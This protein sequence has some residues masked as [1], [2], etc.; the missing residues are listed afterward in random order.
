M[1]TIDSIKK[2]KN[3]RYH[4]K[5]E[6]IG[7]VPTMGSLH[8]GHVSLIQ[9]SKKKNR[10]TVVSIFLNPTQFNNKD[11]LN[12]YPKDFKRDKEILKDLRVDYLFS[13]NKS[14]IYC[15]NYK[16][17][18]SEKEISKILCGR[19]RRGHFEGVLTVV[20]KLLNLVNPKNSYF[21]EKDFQQF[22]LIKGMVKAL[23]LD[24]NC[25]SCP[26]VRDFNGLAISSRN[27]LLT[28]KQREKA[29]NFFR[30]LSSNITNELKIKKLSNLGFKID[31]IEDHFGRTFGAIYY[32]GVRLID[33]VK[34]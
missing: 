27:L 34:K 7:F 17:Q 1:I 12:N 4:L 21:G 10:I 30:I 19:K 32:K 33:N 28:D 16:Y 8:S 3:V 15:D 31:Y 18:V 23:F 22:L 14:D 11:D 24:I 5:K 25:F 6:D 26:T 2:W 20:L 13:P 29:S 9:R